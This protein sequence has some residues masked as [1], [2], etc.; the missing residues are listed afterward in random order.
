MLKKAY[1][2]M[3]CPQYQ[4]CLEQVTCYQ[5]LDF[6][7]THV[8]EMLGELYELFN[9]DEVAPRASIRE[10]WTSALAFPVGSREIFPTTQS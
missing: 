8:S 2:S 5:R 7:E 6:Q 10:I 3:P 1:S 4:E 9:G